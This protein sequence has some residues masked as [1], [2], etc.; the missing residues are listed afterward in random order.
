MIHSNCPRQMKAAT[1]SLLILLLAWCALSLRAETILSAESSGNDG[2]GCLVIFSGQGYRAG[3]TQSDTYNTVSVSAKLTSNGAPNQTGRAYLTTQIGPGT[4]LDQ[5]VAYAEFTFPVPVTKVTL[6]QGLLLRPGTYYLSIIGDSPGWGSCWTVSATNVITATGVSSL[7]GLGALVAPSAYF[8]ATPFF[9]EL[10]IPPELTIQGIKDNR[11]P[12]QITLS[13]NVVSISWS[14]NAAGFNLES[15]NNLAL[16]NWQ[17]IT[18]G[19]STNS[20]RI[21]FTTTA[22]GNRFFRLRKPN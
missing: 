18:Q 5:Q 13:G 1:P 16:N 21:V 3:W 2:F 22:I 17:V 7:G 12:L 6:F 14:T 19:L 10:A 11:P 20:G 4:S 15:I 9:S 8:P